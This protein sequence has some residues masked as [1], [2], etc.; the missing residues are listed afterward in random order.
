MRALPQRSVKTVKIIFEVLRKRN[1]EKITRWKISFSI[2][3]MHFYFI[4][5]LFELLLILNLITFLFSFILNNLKCYKSLSWSFTNHLGFLIAT[6][7]HTRNFLS[8]WELAL[9]M[10][11]GLFFLS[12]WPSLL[13]GAITFSFLICFWRLLVC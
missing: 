11:G 4:F 6:E 12:F 13:W 3:K 8:V 5:L 7:Q 1:N 2:Y 10:F 9:L